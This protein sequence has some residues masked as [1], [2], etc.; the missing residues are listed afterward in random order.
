MAY[1]Q[2]EGT[3]LVIDEPE[4]TFTGWPSGGSPPG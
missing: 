4:A 1:G 2:S 3:V